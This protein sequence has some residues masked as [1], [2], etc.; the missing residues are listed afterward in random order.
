MFMK[1]AGYF[2]ITLVKGSFITLVKGLQL[3]SVI[4]CSFKV[5]QKFQRGVEQKL[6]NICVN[7]AI[8]CLGFLPY[9]VKLSIAIGC[10][11]ENYVDVYAAFYLF[12]LIVLV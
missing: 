11:I 8:F 9:D 4:I 10:I 5:R 12:K 7:L 2:I 3:S 6:M 1:S